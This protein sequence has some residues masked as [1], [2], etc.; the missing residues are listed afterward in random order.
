VTKFLVLDANNVVI[1]ATPLEGS[2]LAP[3]VDD[4]LPINFAV[5]KD[6]VTKVVPQ[7]LATESIPVKDFG[8]VAFDFDV[9]ASPLYFRTCVQIYNAATANWMLTTADITITGTPGDVALYNNPIAAITDIVRVSD[10]Y[11]SYKISVSK[12]GYATKEIQ[13]TNAEL[14]A[15]MENPLIVLLIEP[16]VEVPKGYGLLYNWYTTQP[17]SQVKYGYLYNWYAATDSRNIASA[18]CHVPTFDECHVL[19]NYLGGTNNA[20]G[21]L[22]E[23][24][25]LH[26]TNNTGA[27][28][29][30]GFNG[31]G[32]GER[33]ETGISSYIKTTGAFWSSY[34]SNVNYGVGFGLSGM[35]TGV[36]GGS[37]LK[38][39]GRAIRLLKDFTTLTNGQ[40]GTYTGNDG[41]VYK[42]ICIGTQEWISSNLAETK[43]RDGS[44]I[45]EVTDNTAWAALT[46]G[47]RCSYNNVEANAVTTVSIAPAG[48]HVASAAEWNIITVLYGGR[49]PTAFAMKQAGTTHWGIGN[50]GTNISGFNAVGAG[51]RSANSGSFTGLK[52][53]TFFHAS[54]IVSVGYLYI[55]RLVTVT[56][57]SEGE[58]FVWL[59]NR[60]FGASI[61]LIK[62]DPSTWTTGNTLTDI[63]GNVYQTVKIGNQV[64]TASNW[65]CTHYSDGSE[66]PNVTDNAAWAVL[67]TGAW[68]VYNNDISNK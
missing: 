63:D 37:I 45:P 36:M 29:E 19:F 51:M 13:L 55:L 39:A 59:E 15:Y 7:V 41:K 68:C 65:K 24:G 6:L 14:K 23:L 66:I 40:T 32:I 64:W 2:V 27:T 4:P 28:N 60:S 9:M 33:S 22:K 49:N 3:M 48:W 34:S 17:Q 26:W 18:G 42:T 53:S 30:A 35:S 8:Y 44:L 67:T 38:N 61:R 57:G 31:V 43:Y 25:E 10:G 56:G 11:T 47:G 1:Y 54:N 16:G 46:T 58:C 62:D 52:S 12:T 5:S 21:K 50:D 20:G